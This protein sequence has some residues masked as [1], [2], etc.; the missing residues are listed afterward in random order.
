MANSLS[1]LQSLYKKKKSE[2]TRLINERGELRNAYNRLKRLKDER[3]RLNRR[4]SNTLS[5][6]YEW[7][8]N[9]Y[10]SFLGIGGKATENGT[11]VYESI[12]RVLDEL[13]WQI[14]Q[15]SDRIIGINSLLGDLWTQIQNW[16][17]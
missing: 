17:N 3:E 4:L 16:T 13:N 11:A 15:K 8:G 2:K 12:D 1:S 10:Q 9:T 7:S 14:N 5:E 6:K